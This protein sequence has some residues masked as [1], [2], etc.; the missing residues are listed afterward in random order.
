MRPPRS[1]RI[2]VGGG[3]GGH[4]EWRACGE[5]GVGLVQGDEGGQLWAGRLGLAGDEVA[6]GA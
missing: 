6:Y 3:S 4:I 2:Q 1:R 5:L